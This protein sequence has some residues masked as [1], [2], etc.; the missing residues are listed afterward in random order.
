MEYVKLGNTGLDISP[1][2]LGSM[3]FGEP[4]R[5]Y[6]TWTLPEEDARPLIKA[7]IDAGINF[8]DTANGYS[9][10]ASEEILGRALRDFAVREDIVVATK[11]YHP[12]RAG[13]PNSGGLSRKAIMTEIDASLA[14]LGTDYIDLWQIHRF[15]TSTPLEETL[16]ALHDVVKSGKVRYIG[17]SSMHA[18]RFAKALHLQQ[19]HRWTRFVSMQDHYSLLNREEEREMLPLCADEKIG[20]IPWSPLARGKLARDWDQTTSR[21][22]V[23]AFGANLYRQEQSEKAIV[24]EVAAIAAERGVSRAQIALAWVSGNPAVSAPIVGVTKPHHLQDAIASLDVGLTDDEVARL[25]A[26]YA[27]QPPAGF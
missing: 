13:H 12:M 10:G 11:L 24:E 8:F 1:I 14:R 26:P 27:P 20:V 17:A 22:S 23:D 6:P 16:E 3:S 18:W 25:E 19:M 5:G 21:S 15:D 2:C 4:H 7:A 9:D